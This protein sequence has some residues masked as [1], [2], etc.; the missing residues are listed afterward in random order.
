[1]KNRPVK[2]TARLLLLALTLAVFATGCSSPR[3]SSAGRSG[4]YYSKTTAS[5]VKSGV[6][7]GYTRVTRR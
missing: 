4:S 2:E 3:T 1:M 6:C 5:C 7:G